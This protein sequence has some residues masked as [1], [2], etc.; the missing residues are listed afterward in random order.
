MIQVR[1]LQGA[2]P[3]ETFL[4]AARELTTVANE[5]GATVVHSHGNVPSLQDSPARQHFR[6]G[7]EIVTAPLIESS[8]TPD[9][10]EWNPAGWRI[11][12]TESTGDEEV[13]LGHAPGQS[14]ALVIAPPAAQQ[15]AVERVREGVRS[16]QAHDPQRPEGFNDAALRA[17]RRAASLSGRHLRIT[18][19]GG[20]GEGEAVPLDSAIVT[21][22][23]SW[24]VGQR[25]AI[26]SVDGKLDV[27][28]VHNRLRFTIYGSRGERIECL[29]Q[30]GLLPQ[31]KSALGERVCIRGRIRYRK[32]GIP[33]NVDAQHLR[34]LRSP[35]QQSGLGF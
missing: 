11:V 10:N 1:A 9:A 8:Q 29:F 14:V 31:V 19:S 23:D 2:V 27:I 30:D 34:V 7:E 18:L 26:G 13:A 32:D 21:Q 12:R 24:L 28:S 3:V 16:I 22:I 6:L 35:S 4:R 15:I 17:L 25:D 20:Q 33:A 5:V